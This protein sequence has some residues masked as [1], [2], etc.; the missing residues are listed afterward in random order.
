MGPPSKV[1]DDKWGETR[2]RGQFRTITIITSAV[3]QLAAVVLC[4][5]VT[6]AAATVDDLYQARTIVTGE[7][8]ETRI[9]GIA[10]CFNDVLVK[11]SG[12]PRLIGDP[13]VAV[14]S[15][16]AASYVRDY[17]Y[18]DRMEGIPI[19]DEQGSRDRPYD[20]TVTFEPGK[21]DTA[22][23]ALGREPWGAVR[24][25]IALFVSVR[26]GTIA[27]VL[28]T[29]G[30]LGRDQRDSLAAASWQMGMPIVLPDEAALA[31]AGVSTRSLPKLDPA[32]LDRVAGAIGGDLPLSGELI[33]EK[34][35]EGW[36]A[37]WRLN[38]SGNTYRWQIHNV[39]F[40]DAFRSAMRGAAQILSGNG[41]PE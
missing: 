27:Y 36:L 8:E 6:A 1:T 41:V 32:R 17:R 2:V 11:V 29:D 28:A 26:L 7:R 33:W 4:F 37:N 9:P 31:A 21:I 3:A 35:K 39:N 25:R 22:L 12:D 38:S 10:A 34:R 15:S 14:M 40:D 19:H 16:Q 20:L 23:V 5:C 18:H 30:S 24:P 13:R